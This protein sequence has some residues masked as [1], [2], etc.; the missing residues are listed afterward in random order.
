MHLR[1]DCGE[2]TCDY[3]TRIR[4]QNSPQCHHYGIRIYIIWRCDIGVGCA[5]R[6]MN[7]ITT[8]IGIANERQRRVRRMPYVSVPLG[9]YITLL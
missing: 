8:P 7:I 2:F 3:S 5:E 1:Y 4:R 9:Y 6:M